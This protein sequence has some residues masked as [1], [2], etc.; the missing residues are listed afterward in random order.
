MVRQRRW[1]VMSLVHRCPWWYG[2]TR[3]KRSLRS[4]TVS[5]HDLLSQLNNFLYLDYCIFSFSFI[6]WE[7]KGGRDLL[8][9]NLHSYTQKVITV[10]VTYKHSKGH[11][12]LKWFRL[13]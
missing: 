3:T 10:S 8:E 1:C 2:T 9:D 12:A 6:S 5:F 11:V 7:I 4:T 13:N